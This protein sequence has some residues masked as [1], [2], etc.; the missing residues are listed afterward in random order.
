MSF[1]IRYD[2][3]TVN[4]ASVPYLLAQSIVLYCVTLVYSRVL[5]VERAEASISWRAW[6]MSRTMS[7]LCS[8]SSGGNSRDL[9][10]AG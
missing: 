9:Q 8:E 7:Q 2:A 3:G 4:Q 1:T 6:I 10:M 5:L